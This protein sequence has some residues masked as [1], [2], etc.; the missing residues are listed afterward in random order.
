MRGDPDVLA[1]SE[2]GAPDERPAD[3]VADHAE[4]DRVGRDMSAGSLPQVQHMLEVALDATGVGRFWWDPET[5]AMTCDER[6]TGLLGY[7]VAWPLPDWRTLLH[8][9]DLASLEDAIQELVAGRLAHHEA[10][11]RL[12]HCE[13]HWVWLLL[14]A[15]PMPPEQGR[16]HRRVFAVLTDLTRR[17]RAEVALAE[18]RDLLDGVLDGAQLASWR[19]DCRT[20]RITRNPRWSRLFGYAPGE[21]D[22]TGAG[23]LSLIHP[24]DRAATEQA[25]QDS[26]L[27]RCANYRS[28]YRIRCADGA[29]R[30]V[31]DW[32]RVILRSADGE[33]LVMSG[34][35]MDIDADR[36]A[37][38]EL[39]AG[40]TA[41]AQSE[42]RAR[43]AAL[44]DS[45]TGLGNRAGFN[46]ALQD[47]IARLGPSGSIGV[48][49][50][51]LDDFKLVNDGYGHRAGDH[52]L[53]EV[54]RRL[55]ATCP[56]ASLM[57]R[58]GGDEFAVLVPDM[59]LDGLRLQ[60]QALVNSISGTLSLPS[61]WVRLAV[62]I[63]ATLLSGPSDG[64]TS[65]P[66]EAPV[67]TALYEADLALYHAKKNGRGRFCV[68]RPA[69]GE[70]LRRRRALE[71]D[72]R[73]ALPAGG[74]E[75][76]YQPQRSGSGRLIGVE[77]LARWTHPT[78]GV[79]GPDQFI[80]IAEQGGLIEDLG[81]WAIR[82][83]IRDTILLDGLRVAVNVSPLQ[84]R[85]PGFVEAVRG[86]LADTG[87]AADRLEMEITE[88]VLMTRDTQ[89]KANLLGLR[90]QGISLALDDFG[91]GYSSLSYIADTP[92]SRIKIDRSFTTQ[93][94]SKAAIPAIMRAFR[95]LGAGLGIA[96]MAEGIETETQQRKLEALGIN[97]FQGW[98]H[99]RPMPVD[100]LSALIAADTR[101]RALQVI[102]C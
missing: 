48:L 64:A 54:A 12:R 47:W 37:K 69:M 31:R 40:R 81:L 98:L 50:L 95:D 25:M 42:A 89:T 17:K 80:P 36:R 65:P 97:E 82:R 71:F 76:A 87:F 39:E 86:I 14:H 43:Y 35:L 4:R 55:R 6:L 88:S 24:N 67:D 56:P 68:Y 7:H 5:E 57:A 28:E 101:R 41:L 102:S 72:L 58:I 13:G 100:Q 22:E 92:I 30:W 26:Q 83:A 21:V 29:Y 96:V 18:A 2:P 19:Q 62:S 94:G 84:L 99:G 45:L 70:E 15:S 33:P 8:S 53:V 61:G 63:G 46:A 3:A 91:N 73:S 75:L 49:Y 1:S 74:L 77:A 59:R 20:G 78:Y 93:L 52:V 9:D 90:H 16:A 32:G 44:H 60:A 23:W 66:L 79:V 51:D 34:T 10:E 27:G 11:L 38:E 85:A